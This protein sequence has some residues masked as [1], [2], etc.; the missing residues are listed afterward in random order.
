[1][2]SMIFSLMLVN[3]YSSENKQQI[4][5]DVNFPVANCSMYYIVNDVRHPLPTPEINGSQI[6]IYVDEYVDYELYVTSSP[7]N[8]S[9]IISLTSMAYEIV[10]E[11]DISILADVNYEFRKGV[12]CFDFENNLTLK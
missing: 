12:L 9:T 6:T 10:D 7:Y 4:V 3:F 5:M 1:M 8:Q 2:K 11:R